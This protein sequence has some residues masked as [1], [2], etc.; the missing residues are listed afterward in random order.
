M[1]T[2]GWWAGWTFGASISPLLFL[3]VFIGRCAKKEAL[4]SKFGPAGVKSGLPH[5]SHMMLSELCRPHPLGFCGHVVGARHLNAFEDLGLHLLGFTDCAEGGELP[6][7]SS[8][9]CAQLCAELPTTVRRGC[10]WLG[11]TPCALKA[12]FFVLDL[13]VFP[14]SH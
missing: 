8:C 6:T 2:G 5:S 11:G 1:E 9:S 3:G 13:C 7:A 14:V 12:A 4:L 10:I